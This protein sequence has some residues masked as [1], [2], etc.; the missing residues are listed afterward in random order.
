MFQRIFKLENVMHV[1]FHKTIYYFNFFGHYIFL[2]ANSSQYCSNL[3]EFLERETH[4]NFL[5]KIFKKI[6]GDNIFIK[7]THTPVHWKEYCF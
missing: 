4:L 3:Q 6:M 7:H 1:F 2:S 5:L